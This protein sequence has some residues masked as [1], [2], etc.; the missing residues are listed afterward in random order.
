MDI[1]CMTARRSQEEP[2][3]YV[4][5]TLNNIVFT[6]IQKSSQRKQSNYYKEDKTGELSFVI[7]KVRRNRIGNVTIACKRKWPTRPTTDQAVMT[8]GAPYKLVMRCK[9]SWGPVAPMP[10]K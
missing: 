6:R 9:S 10:V 7:R 1:A 5:Q 2:G 4:K 3:E 8:V